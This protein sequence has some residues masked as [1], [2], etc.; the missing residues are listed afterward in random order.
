M[1][2]ELV[3]IYFAYQK[4][5]SVLEDFSLGIEQGSMVGILGPNG[6]GKSTLFDILTLHHHVKRGKLLYQGQKLQKKTYLKDLGCVFQH[7]SLDPYLTVLENL[8]LQGGVHGIAKHKL[9]NKIK[10]MSDMFGFESRLNQLV[11]DLSGGLARRVEIAKALLHDPKLILLDEPTTGLDPASR[12]EML[13]W[14]K[15]VQSSQ[16]AT[17]LWI[18]HLT[19]EIEHMDRVVMLDKGRVITDGQPQ[20][21]IQAMDVVCIDAKLSGEAKDVP[22]LASMCESFDIEGDRIALKVQ[23]S[24]LKHVLDVLVGHTHQMQYRRPNLED[25]YFQQTGQT[26]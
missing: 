6:S 5:H 12:K 21:L 17:I 1:L 18:T 26:L 13:Q 24:Q 14:M 7:V 10:S 4:G 3:Q 22:D 25:V 16:G 8:N 9:Q 15:R 19:Q 2:L 20:A 11:R 23:Q